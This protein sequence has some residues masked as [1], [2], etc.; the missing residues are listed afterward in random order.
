MSARLHG[1]LN[2]TG[3][4]EKQ[5]EKQAKPRFNNLNEGMIV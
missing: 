1:S 2:P 4:E 3:M 5:G